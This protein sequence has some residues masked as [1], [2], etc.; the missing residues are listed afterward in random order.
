MFF[1]FLPTIEIYMNRETKEYLD[2]ENLNGKS[3]LVKRSRRE[4]KK[5]NDPNRNTN[6]NLCPDKLFTPRSERV[7]LETIFKKLMVRMESHI[8]KTDL[9]LLKSQRKTMRI[10]FSE[11]ML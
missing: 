8:R 5:L 3:S 1:L 10:S 6:Q 7:N 2:E 4:H 9:K 11:A